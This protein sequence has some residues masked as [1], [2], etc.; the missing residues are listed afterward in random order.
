[1]FVD[2]VKVTLRAGKGG[3]GCLTAAAEAMGEASS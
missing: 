2:Q 1:M 3:D